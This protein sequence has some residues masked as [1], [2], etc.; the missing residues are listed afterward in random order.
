MAI[1]NVMVAGLSTKPKTGKMARL[2]AEA[3]KTQLD[4]KLYPWALSEEHADDDGLAI[5]LVP[6]ANHADALERCRGH[7]DLI[8]DFTLPTAVNHNAELYCEAGTPFL[9][10]TTGGDREALITTVKD[11]SIS[12]VVATNMAVPVVIFQEMV[13][14]AAARF[15]GAFK[16]FS[17]CISE[18]HQASKPDPSGTAVGLLNS[19]AALGMSLGK[20]QILMERRPSV[21]ESQLGVPKKHLGGH[22]YHTYMMLSPDGTV[23]LEFRHNVL[24]RSTYV[25]GTLRAIR[26]LA[27]RL[28]EKGKVY[29]MVDVLSATGG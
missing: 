6:P 11:S 15:P 27:E 2:V 23:K 16:G 8:V 21:Q 24:G 19:F 20:D 3:V 28:Q 25:D 14:F 17:L 22:G 26:F 9:M 10:G 7:V 18:S 1:I 13:R 5:K 12:A 29:S 4:M